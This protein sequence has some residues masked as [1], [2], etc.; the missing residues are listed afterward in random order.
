M[1]CLESLWTSC[2]LLVLTD[3]RLESP[4]FMSVVKPWNAKYNLGLHDAR[5]GTKD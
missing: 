4:K 3:L 1:D 5:I 2:G